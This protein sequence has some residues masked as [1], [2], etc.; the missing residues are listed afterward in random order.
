MS[1]PA[2][3]VDR[4]STDEVQIDTFNFP[5]NTEPHFNDLRRDKLVRFIVTEAVA[6]GIFLSSTALVLS[7]QLTEPTL[8]LVTNIVAIAAA[9]AMAMIP[10]IFFRRR[11]D[12]LAA[13]TDEIHGMGMEGSAI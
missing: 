6:T 7:R 1:L 9:A 10:I 12:F 11:A 5:P 8:I 2:T 4:S 3:R 13:N